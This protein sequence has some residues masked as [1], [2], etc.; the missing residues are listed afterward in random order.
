M[1]SNGRM[2]LEGFL[3]AKG[4]VYF[5][6]DDWLFVYAGG[7]LNGRVYGNSKVVELSTIHM[8]T[9]REI[10]VDRS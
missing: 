7:W 4:T 6:W 9:L 3:T 10:G 1:L 8:V 5:W 2:W